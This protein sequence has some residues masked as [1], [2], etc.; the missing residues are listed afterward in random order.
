MRTSLPDEMERLRSAGSARCDICRERSAIGSSRGSSRPISSGLVLPRPLALYA[1]AKI[2]RNALRREAVG[3]PFPTRLLRA[4]R[5]P[6]QPASPSRSSDACSMTSHDSP[7]GIPTERPRPRSSITRSSAIGRC[8]SVTSSAPLAVTWA[9]A[10]SS[11]GAH[12]LRRPRLRTATASQYGGDLEE[13]DHRRPWA[14][15]VLTSCEN[16][17]GSWICSIFSLASR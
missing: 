11:G 7:V 16:R 3:W 12:R 15:M 14:G 13:E 2:T 17:R 8:R 1:G 5:S 9:L 6:E 10:Q 4:W